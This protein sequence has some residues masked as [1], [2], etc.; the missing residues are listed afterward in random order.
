MIQF[1]EYLVRKK[2]SDEVVQRLQARFVEE[3]HHREVPVFGLKMHV[4][5]RIMLFRK[6]LGVAIHRR[7]DLRI[8]YRA[9]TATMKRTVR[10]SAGGFAWSFIA[11]DLQ[12]AA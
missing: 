2:L 6:A 9:L 11:F 7:F 12:V 1:F 8:G 4:H 3:L 10:G 5:G